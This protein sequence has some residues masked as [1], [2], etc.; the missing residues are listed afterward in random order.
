MRSNL[1]ITLP[2]AYYQ[3]VSQSPSFKARGVSQRSILSHG[4]VITIM[5]ELAETVR[6]DTQP[7][8][9]GSIEWLISLGPRGHV[10]FGE[11]IMWHDRWT[12]RRWR[13][14]RGNKQR[15]S[16]WRNQSDRCLSPPSYSISRPNSVS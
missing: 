3:N 9:I 14:N 6:T 2:G 7:D 12:S 11:Q 10:A 4:V 5:I 8:C 1:H 15:R 16:D 13:G